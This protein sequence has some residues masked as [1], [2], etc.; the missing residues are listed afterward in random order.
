MQSFFSCDQQWYSIYVYRYFISSMVWNPIL[1][2][3]FCPSWVWYNTTC[4]KRRIEVYNT[5]TSNF[6]L[7][8]FSSK[9]STQLFSWHFH[10]LPSLLLSLIVRRHKDKG[11]RATSQR[12]TQSGHA[13][14]F[15]HPQTVSAD[16]ADK[17]R[18][19]ACVERRTLSLQRTLDPP[20]HAH[21]QSQT[22]GAS[23]PSHSSDI[24]PDRYT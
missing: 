14:F 23:S 2:Y 4:L 10:F 9:V 17:V 24:Q 22:R 8:F 5:R 13:L 7:Q 21:H 18:Y 19:P 12:L 1:C 20:A 6:L 15:V 11:W 16:R 3:F